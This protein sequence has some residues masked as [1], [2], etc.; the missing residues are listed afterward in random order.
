LILLT[1]Y[2]LLEYNFFTV[3]KGQSDLLFNLKIDLF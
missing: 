2:Y 1:L 3:Y